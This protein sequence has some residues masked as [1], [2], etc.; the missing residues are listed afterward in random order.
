MYHT[1]SFKYNKES[2]LCEGKQFAQVALISKVSELQSKS[3]SLVHRTEAHYLLTSHPKCS[4]E[5]VSSPKN[6]RQF[7]FEKISSPTNLIHH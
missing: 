5:S 2:P 6:P 4:S 1:N 7:K 3:L